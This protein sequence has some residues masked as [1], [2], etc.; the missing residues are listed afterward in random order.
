MVRFQVERLA[1]KFAGLHVRASGVARE[2][3]QVIRLRGNALFAQISF[4]RFPRLR[5][6]DRPS[7]ASC[8]AR[9]KFR[10]REAGWK[11][12]RRRGCLWVSRVALAVRVGCGNASSVFALTTAIGRTE[13]P[14]RAFRQAK[15]NGRCAGTKPVRVAMGNS[16]EP[17][18]RTPVSASNRLSLRSTRSCVG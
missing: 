6:D 7:S 2:A 9:F 1:I 5:S 11:R 14:G 8:R 15:L 18:N 4:R 10:G 3:Q 12:G 13:P 17:T 16:A